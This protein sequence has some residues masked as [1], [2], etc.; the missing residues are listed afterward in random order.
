MNLS[1]LTSELKRRNVFK[2]ATAYAVT[3]WLLIQIAVS[4]EKPLSLPDW[5]DTVIILTVLIGFP[6][7]LI[8]AWVYEWT[9]KGLQKTETVDSEISITSTTSKKLNRVIIFSLSVLIVF[10]LVERI[11]FVG[12]LFVE[13]KPSVAV[14]PFVNQSTDPEN[15]FFADGLAEELLNELAHVEGL[16]VIARTSSFSFKGKSLSLKEIAEKLNVDHILTG[17]VRKSGN[18]LRISTELVK[19]EDES[20]IWSQAYDR[21]SNDIFDI[22][23]EIAKSA[24]KE[25]R[26]QLLPEEIK[27]LD[28]IPTKSAAAYELFLRTRQI[29]SNAPDTLRL[30]IELLNQA[31]A[32]D[33]EFAK[34]HASLAISYDLL[35]E[36]GNYPFDQTLEKMEFHVSEAF[37]YDSNSPEAYRARAWLKRK[38]FTGGPE[39]FVEAIKDLEKVVELVPNHALA[40]NDLQIVYREQNRISKADS[41]LLIAWKLD[42]LN[43][44]ITHNVTGLYANRGELEKAIEILEEALVE[45]PNFAPLYTQMIGFMRNAPYGK[46]EKAFMLA[47]EANKRFPQDVGL[48]ERLVELSKSLNLPPL[49]D[50]YQGQFLALYPENFT[51]MTEMINTRFYRKEYDEILGFAESIL[52][53]FGEP[54][55]RSLAVLRISAHYQKEEYK[56]ALEII[57]EFFPEVYNVDF[58][59][60][61]V[62]EAQ[63]HNDLSSIL[64]FYTYILIKQNDNRTGDYIGKIE[65][66][67]SYHDSLTETRRIQ[68]SAK[69][70]EFMIENEEV[71]VGRLYSQLHV[72]SMRG[73]V[74]KAVS[75]I[76]EIYFQRRAFSSALVELTTDAMFDPI[77]ESKEFQAI[78]T[79]IKEDV[80]SKRAVVIAYLKEQGEWDNAWTAQ[81]D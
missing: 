16:R 56:E 73:E 81:L 34:A 41:T 53:R 31:I 43:K 63:F 14:L 33:P 78:L 21:E 17:S 24:I 60:D 55:A 20:S 67:M 64:E 62:L 6:V 19:I 22:Q 30:E 71:S 59:L 48:Y 70:S 9:N 72:A 66:H 13:D 7:A 38:N 61:E 40:Y 32:L 1:K 5:L 26:V 10:L 74:N 50:K 68:K 51:A 37:K 47:H 46:T 4:I 79:R 80:N 42:P 49:T 44:A 3:G 8:I 15:A 27:A 18:Q 57:D 58:K 12:N 36:Y 65:S 52:Q 39:R 35:H 76:D 54:A 75:L 77:Y 25:L 45:H 23:S 11:F 2:V 69:F 29:R 28:N